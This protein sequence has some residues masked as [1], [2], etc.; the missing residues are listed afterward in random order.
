MA[1]APSEPARACTEAPKITARYPATSGSRFR[2]Y[3]P[4]SVGGGFALKAES[5]ES[6]CS[7]DEASRN[8]ELA[9][10][11]ARLPQIQGCEKPGSSTL[12]QST[13]LFSAG[14]EF[15]DYYHSG[16]RYFT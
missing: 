16:H 10:P 7:S 12:C 2:E 9:L 4:P 6:S 8:C 1:E 5:V 14:H 15:G 11:E 3:S 13:L